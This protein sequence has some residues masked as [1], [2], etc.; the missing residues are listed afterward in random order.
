MLTKKLNYLSVVLF[1]LLLI[2]N[3]YGQVKTRIYEKGIPVS[4]SRTSV[5]KASTLNV[6]EPG[7]FDQLLSGKID[8][9]GD[10]KEYKDKFAMLVPVNIDVLKD[11]RKWEEKGVVYYALSLTSEKALNLSLQFSSFNLSPNAVLSV[12]TDFEI[13]DSITAH[14]NNPVAIWATRIYQGGKLNLLL[15]LPLEEE[16]K[17]TLVI[18]NAGLGY[19]NVGGAFFGLPGRSANCNI[20]VLCPEG[21]GWGN[22][23]SSVALI[24]SNAA[25]HCT[26]TLIMNAC[27]TNRPFLLTANHC[28]NAN[29]QNWVFQFLTWSNTCAPNGTFREDMQFNGCQLR[30]NSAATDFAL[31]E[32]NQIP[33]ANSGLTYAGWNRNAAAATTTTGIHHPRGDL[34]KISND[35][36]APVAVSWITG[37]ANHWRVAFDQGIVQFGSSGSALFDQNHRIVGQLHGNQVNQCFAGTDNN[38]CWC[39]TQIPSIGEYGRFDISWTGEGTNAT[40]LSNWLDPLGTGVI[41]TN[42][43]NINAL[44]ANNAPP[45]LSI[46]GKPLICNSEIY[47]VPN[48]PV[49]ATV[50]WSIPGN[51]G[52]VLQLAQNVPSANQLTITN[53]KWYGIN[54]IL[55]ALITIPGCAAPFPRTMQVGNDNS[56]SASVGYPYTQESCYFYNVFHPSMSGM[57]YSNSSPLFVHQGCMVYVNL[58]DMYGRTV[59]LAPGSP[60]PM[61]WS[62]GSTSYG[63]NTLYFQLPLGSGGIPFTFK[64]TGNGACYER[65]LLFFSISG[66]GRYSFAASP[67]P[68]KNQLTVMAH[69]N[70]GAANEGKI[71]EV[72]PENDL[73]FNIYNF[74]TNELQMTL[75]RKNTKSA[76]NINTSA[77]KS[78]YYVLQV[79]DGTQP[80]SLKF[81]KE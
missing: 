27:G 28:L 34:M 7:I 65:T 41:T 52:P 40:R 63:T 56:T 53:Q 8:N 39:T 48:L 25:E 80:Q 13:T 36:Q 54:T 67:N 1:A 16:G 29:V 43:T 33:P 21:N 17:T 50:T 12:F 70:T 55:T 44:P 62:F 47:T 79:I 60:Q 10:R 42:T 72:F 71:K 5:T 3:V 77:L 78:G 15:R 23:R 58:G 74:N 35:F 38:N 59:S 68:V 73:I 46:S 30:A 75:R 57:M 81:Y 76:H 18:S 49:G 69:D 6:T 11:S 66:N 2:S 37:A 32:L 20:N 24:V 22:E 9:T 26:G 19:K 4:V 64:I 14:E 51:A 31:V 61:F 45:A